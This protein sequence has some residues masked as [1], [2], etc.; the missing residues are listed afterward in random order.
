[1]RNLKLNAGSFA[2][3]TEEEIKLLQPLFLKHSINASFICLYSSE[4]KID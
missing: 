2:T 4:Q 1:M 3:V